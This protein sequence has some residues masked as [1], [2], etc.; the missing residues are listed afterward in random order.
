MER[1]TTTTRTGYMCDQ[2][3]MNRR[4]LLIE[5]ADPSG[6]IFGQV[7]WSIGPGRFKCLHWWQRDSMHNYSAPLEPLDDRICH[8]GSEDED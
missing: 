5:H 1:M 8:D 3:I 4:S 2:F 6:E 7:L